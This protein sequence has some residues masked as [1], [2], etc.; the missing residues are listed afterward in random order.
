MKQT[1]F[2]A[3]AALALAATVPAA[4]RA[5]KMPWGKR[6]I[7]IASH[8]CSTIDAVCPALTR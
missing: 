5:R 4:E 8:R 6:K 3:F 7:A 2:T 1:L